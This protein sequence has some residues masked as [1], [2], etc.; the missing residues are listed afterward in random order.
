MYCTFFG[1]I[2]IFETKSSIAYDVYVFAFIQITTFDLDTEEWEE[3]DPAPPGT[4]GPFI[5]VELT[6]LVQNADA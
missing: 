2:I 6:I 3:L 1:D 5:K 4:N